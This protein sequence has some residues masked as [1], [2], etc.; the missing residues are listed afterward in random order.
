MITL[1]LF[2]AL[3]ALCLFWW[4]FICPLIPTN[5]KPTVG[6]KITQYM[7]ADPPYEIINYSYD[8]VECYDGFAHF[9]DLET[10]KKI[11]VSGCIRI[12]SYEVK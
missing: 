8:V 2:I 1:G 10:K 12:E 4:F 11:I 6:W 3:G 9:I 7:S 5:K